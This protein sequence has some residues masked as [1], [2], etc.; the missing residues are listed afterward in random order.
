MQ[1]EREPKPTDE[2]QETRSGVSGGGGRRERYYSPGVGFAIVVTDEAVTASPPGAEVSRDRQGVK[3]GA[4]EGQRDGSG[5]RGR[6]E[7]R[8]RREQTVQLRTI[9]NTVRI[10]ISIK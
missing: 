10:L 5:G 9:K 3:K 6:K 8:K 4:V 7:R 1:H 2:N